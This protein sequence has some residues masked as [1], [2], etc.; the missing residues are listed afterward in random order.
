MFLFW[1]V[2][3]G[4]GRISGDRWNPTS[5]TRESRG[6]GVPKRVPSFYK[7]S[8]LPY[9][10]S[11]RFS[12]RTR[13]LLTLSYK[14]RPL[15]LAKRDKL[16]TCF[17]QIQSL[18]PV[19]LCAGRIVPGCPAPSPSGLTLND[20]TLR[21]PAVAQQ[22][23]RGCLQSHTALGTAVEGSFSPLLP[24]SHVGGVPTSFA[25]RRWTGRLECGG[26]TRGTF[27]AG[28]SFGYI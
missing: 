26:S 25:C 8:L 4:R 23:Y 5:V 7:E 3:P 27:T 22:S 11:V 10:F 21:T 28:P 9:S 16:Y 14:E 19:A 12:R 6:T 18:Y 15:R 2:V 13:F 24:P 1:V 20:T 17:I